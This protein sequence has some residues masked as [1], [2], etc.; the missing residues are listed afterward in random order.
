[1]YKVVRSEKPDG[2]KE[3]LYI[4]YLDDKKGG[5]Y[6]AYM[7]PEEYKVTM[8]EQDMFYNKKISEKYIKH[9]E[10]ALRALFREESMK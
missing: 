6:K 4:V 10:D 5:E 2:V 3:H 1:M 7:S 8:I 9:F